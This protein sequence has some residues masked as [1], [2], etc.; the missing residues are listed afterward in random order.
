MRTAAVKILVVDDNDV[1]RLYISR[2]LQQQ[3]YQVVLANNGREALEYLQSEPFD[4]VLLDVV[5]PEI[6]GYQVLQHLKADSD[7]R[8]IPVIMISSVD[9]LDRAIRCIEKGAEDYL[10]KPLN[11]ILLRARINACL[12]RKWL[13]DQEQAYLHQLQQE[14]AQAEAANRAKS[15]FLA[16]MS[17]ELRTPLNAIIGYSEILEED[18]QDEGCTE[19]VAD[20]EK[21]RS[22]GKHLLH[23]ID[24]LLDIAKIESG[25][26]ELYLESFD[27][28]SLTNK[29]AN[30]V[31]ALMAANGN[32]LE[33]CFAPNL[34]TMHADLTKVRQILWNLL[35]NAAKFTEHGLVRLMVERRQEDM[36][37][38]GEGAERKD[39]KVHGHLSIDTA[40]PQILFQISDTGIGIPTE[41]QPYIFQ[42]FTQVDDSSTRRYGGTGLGL[43]ISSHFCRIMGG[44]LSVSSESEQGTT[45]SVQ[46]PAEVA[47]AVQ[48]ELGEGGQQDL[49]SQITAERETEGRDDE[50]LLGNHFALMGASPSAS[51]SNLVLVIDDDRTVRDTLVQ[52]LNQKGYRV[53]TTW[54]GGEGLRLAR[55]L[56]PGLIVLDLSMP[57]LDS[58]AVLSTLKADPLLA[59]IPVV[60]QNTPK[61]DRSDAVLHGFVLGICEHL[62]DAD[63]FKRLALLLQAY[64]RSPEA[65]ASPN[66]ILLIQEDQTTQQVLGRLLRKT[67][68]TVTA[69]NRCT[70]A[71]V[72]LQTQRPDVILLDLMLPQMSSFEFLY[73]LRQVP[74][75]Q[76]IPV[77]CTIASDLTS[78][79]YQYLNRCITF[80]GQQG[81]LNAETVLH[82][83]QHHTFTHLP[84]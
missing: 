4:L 36:R 14:K 2:Q 15:A 47:I 28:A 69:V 41:K 49:K 56:Y 84:H 48:P 74:E 32:Q 66:Q 12:E 3:N 80:L 61:L 29:V 13:R 19:Y 46:L 9:D 60:I 78:T 7:L 82:Q 42:P 57:A 11:S 63:A 65:A 51:I 64:Q 30:E 8:A 75:W 1:T 59:Q 68:W 79:D 55:E 77:V 71:V 17:H 72:R 35:T 53:V 83:I 81:T 58:W 26:M 22:S 20:L 40:V 54:S 21:I 5:M 16:N 24:D 52:H 23:L 43:A 34:G 73:N 62:T 76:D 44:T 45:F 37:T 18:L 39:D 6:N 38:V 70:E 67:G 25:K 27:I 50:R 31:Q 33:V 10:A